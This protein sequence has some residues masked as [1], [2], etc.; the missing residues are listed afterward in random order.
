MP[1]P[2]VA[3]IHDQVPDRPRKVIHQEAVDVADLTVRG[4]NMIAL[5]GVATA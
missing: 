5:Y 3:G 1:H 2:P 4:A